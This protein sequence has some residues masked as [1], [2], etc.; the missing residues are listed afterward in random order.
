[1]QDQSGRELARQYGAL[2]TPT[3]IYL[4]KLGVERWRQVGSID[5][6]RVRATLEQ[7]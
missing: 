1:M 7:P 6:G 2:A 5:A 3:F 4:D